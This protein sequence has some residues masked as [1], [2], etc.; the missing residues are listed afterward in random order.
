MPVTTEK[1]SQAKIDSI[2]N[3]L[4]V[5]EEQGTSIDYEVFVDTLKVIP[6]TDSAGRFESY[7]DFVNADTKSITIILYNGQSN[8]NDKYIFRLKEENNGLQGLGMD[9]RIHEKLSTERQK[10]EFEQLETKSQKLQKELKEAGEYIDELE[11]TIVK[12]RNRKF[13][14]GSIN[15]GE[16]GS[17]MLEG[18]IR[19]NPHLL[20]KLPGGEALA[21]V[22]EED[23]ESL[24]AEAP[25]SEVEV[26]SKTS[27]S[28]TGQER[29]YIDLLARI[30][31]VFSEQDFI[32][33][34]HILDALSQNP[35]LIMEMLNV[36]QTE[37]RKNEEEPNS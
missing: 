15:L 27:P 12:L 14:L 37:H 18:F 9:E 11:E 1:Y 25:D 8:R 10:W 26:V 30:R 2:A 17:V 22:I 36:L 3:L 33:V 19:R 28:V 32:Q 29:E 21:G 23:N 24:D 31:K 13:H 16:L 35:A 5:N 6:R 34:M 4:A 20:S 7:T